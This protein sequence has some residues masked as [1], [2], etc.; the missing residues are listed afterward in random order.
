MTA[1]VLSWVM[2]WWGRME[3]KSPARSGRDGPSA[4]WACAIFSVMVW[5][6]EISG[7]EKLANSLARTGEGACSHV[8]LAYLCFF[9][10]A[11]DSVALTGELFPSRTS[12]FISAINF[13]TEFSFSWFQ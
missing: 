10:F 12:A 8:V 1:E 3:R 5:G 7:R 9:A 6:M 4:M 11:L 2:T 13:V